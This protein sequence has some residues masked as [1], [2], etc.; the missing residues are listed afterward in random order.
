LTEDKYRLFNE[1]SSIHHL[2]SDDAPAVLSYGGTLDQTVTNVNIVIHHAPFGKVLYEKNDALGIRCVVY[3]GKEV[4]GGDQ[5][6]STFDFLK[7]QSRIMDGATLSRRCSM[8]ASA[9]RTKSDTET[10]SLR[11]FADF[12]D[13]RFH[14]CSATISRTV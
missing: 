1:A 6:L 14:A 5:R 13:A 9:G 4:P 8:A 10:A 3:T 7:Q 12:I 11:C 2:T